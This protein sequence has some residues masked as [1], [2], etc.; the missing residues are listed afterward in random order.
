MFESFCFSCKQLI[1]YYQDNCY[2][3][4]TSSENENP[5]VYNYY[6]NQDNDHKDNDH[7]DITWGFDENESTNCDYDESEYLYLNKE[8]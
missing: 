5:N 7:K 4:K 3:C 8:S 6:F 1:N 2:E